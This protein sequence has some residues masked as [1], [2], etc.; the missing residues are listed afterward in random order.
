LSAT[1]DFTGSTALVTGA[2]GDIGR[3]VAVR[4][5]ASGTSVVLTDLASAADRLEATRE[6]CVEVGGDQMVAAITADVTEPA[7]IEACFAAA[8]ERL[9]TPDLVFNN[10]G[11]QG[12][13]VGTPDYPGDDFS[14][15]FQVNVE[16]VFN[17]LGE[18]A[19]RLRSAGRPGSIVNT[20]SMAGVEGAPN[21]VAYSAS[22]AAVIGLTRTAAKDLAPYE[23]RVNAVSPA[24][25]GP[26]RM[27]D[28][29]VELQ[30][31]AGSQ[32]YSSDPAE[33]AAEMVGQVP[34]RR[35]GALDEVAAAVL[36]L[37]S[38]EASYVTGQN[39]PITGGI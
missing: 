9:G 21:M 4:L 3:A 22:K 24:F 1:Y 38:S 37:L 11:Y 30:A 36:W 2:A 20:A 5:A 27:W 15:V 35:Y 7:S 16:G 12:A 10:A 33:V 31:T 28:R 8:A 13:F 29:Q 32:Y 39:L 26:G 19:R 14:R 23:I 17:V 6:R 25:I 34:M 18:A